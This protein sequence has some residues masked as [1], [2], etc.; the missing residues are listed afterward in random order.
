MADAS[1]DLSEHG[2]QVFGVLT[3][4][5]DCH[6]A[7]T[8]SGHGEGLG[9][10][11]AGQGVRIELRHIRRFFAVEDDLPVRL[12][13]DQE[14]VVAKFR[15]LPCQKIGELLQRLL[16]VQHSRRVVGGVDQ[17]RCHILGQILLRLFK[18]D[19]ES[20]KISGNHF[21]PG[22]CVVDVR[23]VLREIGCEYEHLV[24]GL[25]NS[26]QRVRK[27]AGRSG[28]GKNMIAGIIHS[29]S[30]VQGGRDLLLHLGNAEG[31]AVTVEF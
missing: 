20:L 18:I 22:S 19:L 23:I 10:G 17:D 28:C 25:R 31:G 6:V 12:V 16:T 24:A 2:H 1:G 11:I 27:S 13:R 4:R 9:E 15:G 8:L 7:D 29:E 21:D 3:G 26:A 14:H 5:I 30:A